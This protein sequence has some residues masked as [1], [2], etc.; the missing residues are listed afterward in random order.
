MNKLRKRILI[1]FFTLIFITGL[2]AAVWSYRKA[3]AEDAHDTEIE[4]VDMA[5]RQPNFTNI[6]YIIENSNDSTLVP[7]ANGYDES[8]YHIVEIS[9]GSPS[10]LQ[11]FSVVDVT[12]PNSSTA[13]TDDDYASFRTLVLTNHRS[14]NQPNAMKEKKI[15]YAAFNTAT[16]N[17]NANGEVDD[18]EAALRYADF[19]Y[20]SIDPNSKYDSSTGKDLPANVTTW[21]NNQIKTLKKPC[22]IDSPTKTYNSENGSLT[23][24]KALCKI[25]FETGSSYNSFV[26]GKDATG[27]TY[28]PAQLFDRTSGS[29]FMPINGNLQKKNWDYVY[30]TDGTYHYHSL[31]GTEELRVAKVLSIHSSSDNTT[32]LMDTLKQGTPVS[33]T[34]S[35]GAVNDIKIASETDGTLIKDANDRQAYIGTFKTRDAYLLGDDTTHIDFWS[36]YKTYSAFPDYVVFDDISYDKSNPALSADKLSQYDLIILEDSLSGVQVSDGSGA[37]HKNDY[38]TFVSL[39]YANQHIVYGNTMMPDGNNNNGQITYNAENFNKL[40]SLLVDGNDNSRLQSVLVSCRKDM[41]ELYAAKDAITSTENPIANIINKGSYR[42]SSSSGDEN[43]DKY[44]VLEVQP[45]YPVDLALAE[46]IAAAGIAPNAE[47]GAYGNVRTGQSNYFFELDNIKNGEKGENFGPD[48]IKIGATSLAALKSAGGGY[49]AAAKSTLQNN[50]NDLVSYY[51]WELTP[52]KVLHILEQTA[53]FADYGPEKIEIVRM[54]AIEFQSSRVSLKDRYDM[55]YIGGDDSGIKSVEF[56]KANPS[57]VEHNNSDNDVADSNIGAKNATYYTMYYHNGDLYEYNQTVKEGYE[58]NG[59]GIL[60]GNDL[61]YDK[62]TEL[63]E[64]VNAGMPVVISDRLTSAFKDVY[65]LD[66]SNDKYKQHVLDPDS[67]MYK[68]LKEYYD[69]TKNGIGTG[70][71]DNI[72]YGF[73]SLDT[74]MIENTCNTGAKYSEGAINGVTVFGGA[75]VTDINNH[76]YV[77]SSAVNESDIVNLINNSNSRPKFVLKPKQTAYDGSTRQSKIDTT[78]TSRTL[79]FAWDMITPADDIEMLLYIDDNVDSKYTEDEI[80]QRVDATAGK[81]SYTLKDDYSGAVNCQIK[82]YNKVTKSESSIKYI[83]YKISPQG[84]K[85]QIDILQILPENVY[86]KT[87]GY[88]T[89]CTLFFCTEC[90]TMGRIFKG[91]HY[92]WN[93]KYCKNVLQA[94]DNNAFTEDNPD[95][96][97]LLTAPTVTSGIVSRDADSETRVS[98]SDNT[99]S[100]VGNN[101]GVHVH[102]FGIFDYNSGD[103]TFDDHGMDDLTYNLADEIEGDYDFNVTIMSTREFEKMVSDAEAVYLSS[104]DISSLRDRYSNMRSKYETFYKELKML[105]DEDIYYVP[106]ALY[107]IRRRVNNISGGGTGDVATLR[108]DIQNVYTSVGI[109]QP[110]NAATMDPEALFNNLN[111]ELGITSTSYDEF[112]DSLDK[113]GLTINDHIVFEREMIELGSSISKLRDYTRAQNDLNTYCDLLKAT[114]TANTDFNSNGF[115]DDNGKY[116]V[117]ELEYWKDHHNYYDFYSLLGR[118]GQNGDAIPGHSKKICEEFT[119]YYMPWRDAMIYEKYFYDKYMEFKVKAAVDDTG[120]SLLTNVY[121]IIIVGPANH[122]GFDDIKDIGTACLKRYADNGGKVLLYH[123]TIDT[124]QLGRA[125][126]ESF[127]QNIASDLRETFGM[128]ARHLVKGAAD[129]DKELVNHVFSIPA[130]D[131]SRTFSMGSNEGTDTI[132]YNVTSQPPTSTTSTYV[133]YTNGAPEAIN[134]YF[135]GAERTN[136]YNFNRGDLFTSLGS[137]LGSDV[138]SATVSIYLDPNGVVVTSKSKIENITH[139]GGATLTLNVKLYKETNWHTGN[140]AEVTDGSGAGCL[141]YVTDDSAHSNFYESNVISASYASSTKVSE[142]KS[143][144]MNRGRNS[145]TFASNTRDHSI[146]GFTSDSNK[147]KVYLVFR[148]TDAASLVGSDYEITDSTTGQTY[149]GSV[150]YVDVNGTSEYACVFEV[151]NWKIKSGASISFV[152]KNGYSSDKYFLSTLATDGTNDIQFN[153][154]TTLKPITTAITNRASMGPGGTGYRDHQMNRHMYRYGIYDTK[155][156]DYFND[157]QT[158]Q[159]CL[160]EFKTGGKRQVDDKVSMNNRGLLTSYPF[161]LP[162]DFTITS[163]HPQAFDLDVESD[164]MTV[165]YSFIAGSEGT[166]SQMHAADPLDGT[167]N[168]FVYQYNSITYCGAGHMNVTGFGTN[169]REERMLYINIIVNSLHKSAIGT[170]VKLY[171]EN[172]TNDKIDDGTANAIIKPDG[173][174][175]YTLEVKD[176]N[177]TPA[178]SVKAMID[179]G[180][181]ITRVRAWYDLDLPS[182]QENHPFENPD[183]T[184]TPYDH[185]LFYDTDGGSYDIDGDGT[186]DTVA[187]ATEAELN[188]FTQSPVNINMDAKFRVGDMKLKQEYFDAYD[189]MHTYIVVCVTT[190]KGGKTYNTYRKIRINLKP[191]M[192]DLT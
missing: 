120:K 54:S 157:T 58:P 119:D 183:T 21:L 117:A 1:T 158:R 141:V 125:N 82:A 153:G 166:Q 84:E 79:T 88:K 127:S 93:G 192:F 144:V 35:D 57:G 70:T 64:Y 147:Q 107:D 112:S 68:F 143:I 98:T 95:N 133:Y 30:D 148:G 109:S 42:P 10:F 27:T 104:S 187:T 36:A 87:P 97:F 130:L 52:A 14:N 37:D 20:V 170:Q 129:S 48:E 137:S 32:P 173:T 167:E 145:Y 94:Q 99:Y 149:S 139:G 171:D 146:T 89:D 126:G 60:Y 150:S 174:G 160:Y 29:T 40:Y 26:W 106:S 177:V 43:A 44:R 38:M 108:A 71:K 50:K 136:V 5:T 56:F 85:E 91:N 140:Y 11:Y 86:T 115:R 142:S 92:S 151:D 83:M 9:S 169:N 131:S 67:N 66:S 53:N 18:L 2:G 13:D 123:D 163:T 65:K 179:G 161:S 78:L 190:T 122:F 105:L 159:D 47:K 185:K 31:D 168:Y 19:I 111:S 49:S 103:H 24:F 75:E 121:S 4:S 113:Y 69:P 33:I 164:A 3:I 80:F 184:G 175:N 124:A 22:I 165:Y 55:I 114:Y 132:V 45:S 118:S 73:N 72:L 74:V 181:K 110:A 96:F 6:D 8:E 178:F 16:L 162:N 134:G 90:Q 172:A 17:T 176:S 46:Q 182:E 15:K 100:Y 81:M 116:F 51:A 23:T 191:Y 101:L 34:V 135:A 138:D 154:S 156:E 41:N 189:G 186:A 77:S 12:D 61:T 152:P 128:D 28:T 76:K 188:A 25:L 102:D 7:D 63:E 62:F 155:A 39:M 59:Y 180:E